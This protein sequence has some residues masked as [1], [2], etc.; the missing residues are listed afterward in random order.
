MPR[1]A[2]V[3]LDMSELTYLYFSVLQV[4]KWIQF[5][6]ILIPVDGKMLVILLPLLSLKYGAF[7][8]AGGCLPCEVKP[9]SYL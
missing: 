2:K 8:S 4:Q 5:F 6:V 9:T 1:A 3:M 7:C